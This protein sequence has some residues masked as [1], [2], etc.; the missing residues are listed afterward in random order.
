MI[1]CFFNYLK[2]LC[3]DVIVIYRLI[4]DWE[5]FFCD[6]IDFFSYGFGCRDDVNVLV[7]IYNDIF[8]KI[9]DK[10]VL[11]KMII[12]KYC[13]LVKWYND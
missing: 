5:K 6:I 10:Y 12:I 7:F 1:I 8:L 13:C 4:L 2:L 9:Y 3:F 11:F